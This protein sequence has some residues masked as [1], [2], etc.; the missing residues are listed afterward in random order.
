MEW[1]HRLKTALETDNKEYVLE[2]ET[3]RGPEDSDPV[4][5]KR[6]YVKHLDDVKE[7]KFVMQICMNDSF[8]RRFTLPEPKL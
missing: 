3:P 1:S 8:K 2:R 6:V 7:A 4:D 5:L